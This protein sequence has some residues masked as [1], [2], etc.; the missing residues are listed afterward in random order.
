MKIKYTYTHTH[1][2]CKTERFMLGCCT[3]QINVNVVLK[4]NM[5]FSYDMRMKVGI[6]LLS[7]EPG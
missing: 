5:G 2:K 7:A 1:T 4:V 6:A 3:K